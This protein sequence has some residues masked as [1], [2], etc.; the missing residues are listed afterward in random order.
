[1][2]TGVLTSGSK[3]G[4]GKSTLAS[5]LALHLSSRYNVLLVD[6]G[7][8]GSSTLLALGEDPG[9][10]Y[11]TDYFAGKAEW[12]EVVCQ[13]PYSRRLFV[14]PSPP[15]IGGPVVP[16]ML[17]ELLASVGRHVQVALVDLPAYPGSLLDPVV[18]LGDVVLLLVN[19]NP[20][21]F[22][23]A[24]RAYTGRGLV[25]PVLNKYH[26][27][28]RGWLERARDR[29]NAVFAFPFDPALT[30]SKTRTLPEAM[31]YMKEETRRDLSLL[32]Q[33]ILKPFVKVS[34]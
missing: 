1:M 3:G 13:S 15:R 18:D 27:V 20:L 17:G 29:W 9:P 19:P 32:A 10:P 34:R 23:A 22:E 6:M 7:E 28:H 21:S 12:G 26:P 11:L 8:G 24:R 2:I 4:T 16:D 31:K 30:F 14:A 5:V 25:L 33:R